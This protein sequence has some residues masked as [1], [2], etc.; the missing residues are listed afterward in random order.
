MRDFKLKKWV[1]A[2]LMASMPYTGIVDAAGLGRLNVLSQLGQP[3]SAEIELLNVSKEELATLKANLASP[4]AYQAAN[5]QFNPSLNALRLS[6]E[7][8]P[9]G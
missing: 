7:R 2:G 6:V 9:N 5:L 3:F 1:A 4:A 8:R